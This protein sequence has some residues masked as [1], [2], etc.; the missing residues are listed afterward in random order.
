[1]KRIFLAAALVLG[2]ISNGW[3]LSLQDAFGIWSAS[4][5][6]P[7]SG[8]ATTD[9]FVIGDFSVVEGVK[10]GV[11]VVGTASY[12]A[13]SGITAKGTLGL[14]F[15]A[16]GHKYIYGFDLVETP[17]MAI[18]GAGEYGS[19]PEGIE[20]VSTHTATVQ[21]IATWQLTSGIQSQQHALRSGQANEELKALADAL[22]TF[23]GE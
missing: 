5:I 22:A 20:I 4:H 7:T 13:I 18:V 9:T 16:H 11:G 1:M 14:A 19:V 3:A 21:R 10:I 15:A 12:P 2:M 8:R 6:S 17:G 23:F